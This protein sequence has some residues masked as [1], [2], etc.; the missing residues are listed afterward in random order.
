MHR[1]LQYCG[2]VLGTIEGTVSPE[3]VTGSRQLLTHASPILW[4]LGIIVLTERFKNVNAV[5]LNADGQQA[6]EVERGQ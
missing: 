2:E 3:K 5:C 6:V 4:E 1:V